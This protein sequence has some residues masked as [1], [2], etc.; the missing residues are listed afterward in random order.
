M[1]QPGIISIVDQLE[2]VPKSNADTKLLYANMIVCSHLFAEGFDGSYQFDRSTSLQEIIIHTKNKYN[3]Y[4]VRATW[5]GSLSSFSDSVRYISAVSPL[6]IRIWTCAS[7]PQTHSWCTWQSALRRNKY[8]GRRINNTHRDDISPLALLNSANRS[9]HVEHRG[10][11]LHLILTELRFRN[12]TRKPVLDQPLQC[13]C[14]DK[15]CPLW[16]GDRWGHLTN[17]GLHPYIDR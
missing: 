6:T 11:W 15:S 16:S 8:L 12:G 5:S 2:S 10:T 14:V 7:V 1:T 13:D 17:I 3:F 4:Y 9:R